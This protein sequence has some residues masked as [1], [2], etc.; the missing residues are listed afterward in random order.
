MSAF[1]AEV[2]WLIIPAWTNAAGSTR[3]VG[4]Q[5]IKQK[6]QLVE[7]PVIYV[8]EVIKAKAAISEVPLLCLIFQ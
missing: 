4:V 5:D 3:L 7:T 8:R 2:T 1:A 6:N